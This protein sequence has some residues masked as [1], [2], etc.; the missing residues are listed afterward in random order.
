MSSYALL[1]PAPW[2]RI[3][4]EDRTE[5]RA[6]VRRYIAEASTRAPEEI[7]RDDL[8]ALRI[9][10]EGRMTRQMDQLRDN[11]G[12]DFYL[13]TGPLHG[14]DLNASFVVSSVI[15]D[16]SADAS[17]VAPVL[18]S[19]E[20]GGAES[21]TLGG[22]P[23]SRA[24]EVVHTDGSDLVEAGLAAR[25]VTYTAAVPGDERRWAIV[26]ATV[27]GDGDPDSDHTGL[28]VELFD[29]IMTTWRWDPAVRASAS[30]ETV[31]S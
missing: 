25:K 4:L 9:E 7:S 17:W 29:A 5:T 18:A 24:E 31:P 21:V 23:W 26:A 10:L 20:A 8:A 27:I 13:P 6:A 14:V 2:R 12:V 15:P 22:A 28:V 3:P 11:G 19:L 30:E 16:A 1:L